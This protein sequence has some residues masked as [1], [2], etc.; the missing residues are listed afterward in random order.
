MTIHTQ[1]G[2]SAHPFHTPILDGSSSARDRAS[3]RLTRCGHSLEAR[4]IGGR[5][6]F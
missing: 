4:L 5:G 1:L 2:T 3:L 6:R